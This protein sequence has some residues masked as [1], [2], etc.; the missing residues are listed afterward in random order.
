[1][2]PTL[3]AVMA[4][5][6]LA[7]SASPLQAA[8]HV[9][10][11]LGWVP[12]RTNMALF[13]DVDAIRKS[14][15]AKKQKWF[16]GNDPTSGLDSL[17]PGINRLVI[18]SQFDPTSGVSWEVIVAGLNKPVTDAD[19]LKGTG[20]TLD[21]IGGKNVIQT[22]KNKFA[23][24]LAPGV[25]GAYQPANRQDTGR[26]LREVNGKISPNLPPYLKQAG[27]RVAGNTA[28]VLAL[29]TTDMFDPALVKVG[30]GKTNALKGKAAKVGPVA[31]LFG[32]MHGLTLSIQ[33]TDKL[34]GEIRLDFGADA[35]PLK[36]V[37]Q[38]LLLELLERMGMHSDE[39]EKWTVTMRQNAVTFGGPL[40]REGVQDLLSPIIRPSV[41]ALDQTEHPAAPMSKAEASLKYF[42]AVQQKMNEVRKSTNPTFAKLAT[43]FNHAARHID[44]LPIL[45]VDDE[46]LDWGASVATTFRSMAIVAQT[47]GGMMTLAEANKSM[48]VVSSPNYYTGSV[49]GYAGG[50][51]GGY[52]YGYNY[53]VPSGTTSTTTV[54][55]YGQIANIQF[56]TKEQEA[57][58][59]RNTWK[60]MDSA[61]NDVRR[62]MVKKYN[63]E[64]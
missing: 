52:G 36:D 6:L 57:D 5:F 24:N 42:K 45:N 35:E 39:M 34:T 46:L 4:V 58:Y 59:R 14:E 60:N 62:K 12:G 38:P 22:K 30:L 21:N 29:D 32:Q 17:P 44:D 33:V 26:W 51:Y 64:F 25:A 20:G 28:V 54:S 63:I 19:L 50:Y 1:M 56:M 55:N 7:V 13:V 15:I 9:S 61:T 49:S 41:G 37:A 8:D 23:V 40:T 48:S 11:L 31:D 43:T 47:A 2:R 10:D 27:A 16:T 3:T 53:A 18:A